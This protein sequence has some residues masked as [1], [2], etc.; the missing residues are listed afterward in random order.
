[1]KANK[2][3]REVKNN[4]TSG[5]TEDSKEM[6]KEVDSVMPFERKSKQ[7]WMKDE[8]ELR[9]DMEVAMVNKVIKQNSNQWQLT[10]MEHGKSM[11]KVGLEV[12]PFTSKPTF[13]EWI[14]G[15]PN[16]KL[17]E[18]QHKHYQVFHW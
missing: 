14:I 9:A 17:D 8:D 5:A 4:E 15:V 18:N 12:Q 16:S 6:Q 10:L 7:L 1:M 11:K 3:K 2:S 13:N